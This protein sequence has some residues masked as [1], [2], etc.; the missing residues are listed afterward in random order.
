M[1]RHLKLVAMS[2]AKHLEVPAAQGN[3]A[4]IFK[5]QGKYPEVL[6]MF[7]KLLAIRG[8][9]Y[10]LHHADEAMSWNNIAV[11]FKGQGKYH[12][13]LKMYHKLLATKEKIYSFEH[14]EVLRRP[15]W[16][17]QHWLEA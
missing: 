7:Q 15:A 6:K 17:A 3:I 14:L 5:V 4:L 2:T 13:A 11:V 9:V 10:S 12:E 8:K 1:R 16:P